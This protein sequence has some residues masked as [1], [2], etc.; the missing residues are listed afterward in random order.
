MI[1]YNNTVAGFIAGTEAGTLAH[2][3]D[4][5]VRRR[6]RR[7]AQSELRS[8]KNSLQYMYMVLSDQDIPRDAGVAIEYMIPGTA[9]R[10]DFII[11]GFDNEAQKAAVIIE[12]KQWE[13]TTTPTDDVDLVTTWIGGAYRAVPHPC[14]QAK[15]YADL[16]TDFN[17]AVRQ[18]HIDLHPCA[19]LHNYPLRRENEPLLDPRFHDLVRQV[20]LFDQT[21]TRQLRDFVKRFVRRGDQKRILYEIES[22]RIRPSK[23]LQDR[24]VSMLAGNQE[25]TMIDDQ[26][27]VFEHALS[28]AE[29]THR[30]GQKRVL[31]VEGGPGT[32][33]SVVAI[34]LL[35]ELT[36]RD[37]LV[38]YISRNAA[39]R[40]VYRSRLKG[41][42]RMS[43]VDNLFKGSGSY[44]ELKPDTLD[45]AIVDEAH[46][47]NEKSG[48]YGNKGENQI[49]EIIRSSRC[50]IFFVDED[51]MISIR[52]IGSVAEIRRQA[53]RAGAQL[54][55]ETLSS[56]FR[57][58][59]SD[60]YLSW[61]DD[62]LQIRES[63]YTVL[64]TQYDIDVVDTPQELEAW[65]RA[66]NTNNKARI[67]AGYCWEWPT[68][69][70]SNRDFHDIVIEEHNFAMSWNLNE[71]IW[72]I[73]PDSV[74]Q[75]GCIHTSQGL[76][77][78]YTGVIIGPDM[79]F[80][81]G[82]IQTDYRRRATSDASLR[83]I[84]KLARH[85]PE[86]ARRTADRI[87]R[88]TYRTLMTRG[89]KGCRIFCTDLPL[90]RYLKTRLQEA[91]LARL[92]ADVLDYGLGAAEELRRYRTRSD[93]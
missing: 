78:E 20:P 93:S 19:F 71:G 49:Y 17:E 79:F 81:K 65:V 64:D 14:Y 28:M 92:D 36:A 50:S 52:D 18:G 63:A 32:G 21:G 42:R 47:L 31:L 44:Y 84:G 11:S 80:A 55:M 88:N 43:S 15:S 39:P 86:E 67:L 41:H 5:L 69:G 51:Q 72:A 56:Q 38:Q 6:F 10:I 62:V 3:L 82:S 29:R 33:K 25:F 85:D 59:G 75:A 35:V 57:C 1:I 27:V 45:V 90:A 53:A 37:R 77:F 91:R 61:L 76:E 40:Q 30:D 8:W 60:G 68:A 46:R 66:R 89:M 48:F 12:L 16:L 34:N 9:K 24:L 23:S 58:N 26:K 2:H 13:E 22:G 83:G 54:S 74:S 87:I 4:D 7:P 70:R 73:E